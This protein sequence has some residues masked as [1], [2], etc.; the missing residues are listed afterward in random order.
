[1]SHA[2]S[3]FCHRQHQKQEEMKECGQ[4]IEENEAQKQALFRKLKLTQLQKV[5]LMERYQ[6]IF[7]EFE[8]IIGTETV[9]KEKHDQSKQFYNAL[10]VKSDE[11]MLVSDQMLDCIH[12]Y[13]N[14]QRIISKE[15]DKIQRFFD[16]KWFIFSQSYLDWPR[17]SILLW[18]KYKMKWL[19]DNDK[20][21]RRKGLEV[22][23]A[24]IKYNISGTN[25]MDLQKYL[26]LNQDW[27]RTISH[28]I[29]EL[30]MDQTLLSEMT[31]EQ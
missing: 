1:M 12:E 2:S 30:Q 18:I 23:H 6:S 27:K 26:G 24:M 28:H 25:L 20:E 22:Q 14:C 21:Q 13:N 9:L 31:F 5:T 7:D 10:C 17:T 4:S 3:T 29:K 19:N 16:Q 11:L 15:T 8:D